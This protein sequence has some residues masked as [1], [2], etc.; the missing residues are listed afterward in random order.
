MRSNV[1]EIARD[2]YRISTFQ[3]EFGI[4]FNQ[5]LIADEQP[6]RLGFAALDAAQ[7]SR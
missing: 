1:S 5:F 3:P 2:T 6:F 4:Q 7:S